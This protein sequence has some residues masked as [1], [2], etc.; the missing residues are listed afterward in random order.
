WA[1]IMVLVLASAIHWDELIAAYNLKRK[2]TISQDVPFLLSLS[3]KVLP[4]LENNRDVLEKEQK[5]GSARI[6]N[7]T[8]MLDE[9]YEKFSLRQ[10]E[11]SWLSWNYADAVTKQFYQKIGNLSPV[12]P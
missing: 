7:Y 5:D 8:M 6:C 2:D 4:L 10:Q 12:R 3:D 11:L 1:G 9:R